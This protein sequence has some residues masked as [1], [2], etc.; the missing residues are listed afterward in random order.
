M[1]TCVNENN[2]AVVVVL[3]NL[4]FQHQNVAVQ[5]LRMVVHKLALSSDQNYQHVYIEAE[6]PLPVYFEAGSLQL[7]HVSLTR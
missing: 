2:R 3:D 1:T 7:Q 6:D 4:V 5:P